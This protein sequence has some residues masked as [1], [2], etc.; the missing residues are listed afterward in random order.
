[1]LL[2]RGLLNQVVI[3]WIPL[4][5]LVSD[6]TGHGNIHSS[7]LELQTTKS[8]E[9]LKARLVFLLHADITLGLRLQ[10]FRRNLQ[11]GCLL[12][13]AGGVVHSRDRHI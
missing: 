12:R 9:I 8:F 7:P 5:V 13:P 11:F 6:L 2:K 10:P 4:N 1:M 3:D